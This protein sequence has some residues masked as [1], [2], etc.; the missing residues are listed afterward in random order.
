MAVCWLCEAA[1]VPSAGVWC[2]S[3]AGMSHD[4]RRHLWQPHQMTLAEFRK[5]RALRRTCREFIRGE[6]ERRKERA[7]VA[8][9]LESGGQPSDIQPVMVSLGGSYG[10]TELL[11]DLPSW[12]GVGHKAAV[13][14]AWTAGRYVPE[15]VLHE[16]GLLGK[17]R[18]LPLL[19]AIDV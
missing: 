16:Y 18:Q 9:H 11:A 19:E 12:D 14:A 1:Q 3:C 15:R 6:K 2:A 10:L 5:E 7:A 8:S 13:F 17:P 4:A